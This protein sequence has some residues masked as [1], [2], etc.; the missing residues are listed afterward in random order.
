MGYYD[1]LAA[2][3]FK[4][5]DNGDFY[6]YPYAFGKGRRF[7]D[8]EAYESA[9]DYLVG[10][11][12]W[13]M[14]LGVASGIAVAKFGLI[15]APIA[16]II[17]LYLLAVTVPRITRDSERVDV[18]DSLSDSATRAGQASSPAKLVMLA[19][20]SIAFSIGGIAMAI[21]GKPMGYFTA[22][23]FGACAVAGIVQLVRR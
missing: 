20:G 10:T 16:I 5:G 9:K 1:G 13:I 8:E 11:Y 22:I 14:P 3:S 18:K 23:F 19:L 7:H 21:D 15:A 2:G 6:V 17:V 12:R 4:V